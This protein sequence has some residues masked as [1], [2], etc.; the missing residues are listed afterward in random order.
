MKLRI[1]LK[2]SD[3]GKF[4]N[5][6]AFNQRE[7]SVSINLSRLVIHIRLGINLW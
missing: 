6:V 2:I 3:L 1:F 5:L 4:N 7:V